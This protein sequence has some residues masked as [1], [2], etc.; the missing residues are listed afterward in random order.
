METPHDLLEGVEQHAVD[1]HPNDEPILVGLNVNV[2]R[3][4]PDSLEED[5]V[6]QLDQWGPGRRR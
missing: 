6:H 2:R 1:P 3:L 4:L 5:E